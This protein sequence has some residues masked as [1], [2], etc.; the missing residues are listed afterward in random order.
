M[1]SMLLRW[2]ISSSSSSSARRRG[3]CLVVQIVVIHIGVCTLF[4]QCQY[5]SRYIHKVPIL[6]I[7]D[8]SKKSRYLLFS[9]TNSKTIFTKQW[10]LCTRSHFFC[11]FARLIFANRMYRLAGIQHL[12]RLH[13]PISGTNCQWT[14]LLQIHIIAPKPMCI[15]KKLTDFQFRE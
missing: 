2:K 14:I 8:I 13:F 4:I 3:L 1:F 9:G 10:A 12:N 6:T 5:C 15:T 7:H 11:F